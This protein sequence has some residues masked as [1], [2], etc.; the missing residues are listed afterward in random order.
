MKED[1]YPEDPDYVWDMEDFSYATKDWVRDEWEHFEFFMDAMND[2]QEA[3]SAMNDVQ[4]TSARQ[5][6]VYEMERA[7]VRSKNFL[8]PDLIMHGRVK[9][10]GRKQTFTWNPYEFFIA[11]HWTADEWTDFV[12]CVHEII[13]GKYASQATSTP[14][15]QLFL[16]T[17]PVDAYKCN[18]RAMKDYINELSDYY[19]KEE[20]GRFNVMAHEERKTSTPTHTATPTRKSTPMFVD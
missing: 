15:M 8:G 10:N 17:Y 18:K 3:A 14:K 19:E 16:K 20:L 13:D 6:E 2:R 9:R 11:K 4:A 5:T 12:K 1:N 7:V